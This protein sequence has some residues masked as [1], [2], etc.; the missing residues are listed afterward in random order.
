MNI[1]ELNKCANCGACYNIC[2]QKAI[3]VDSSEF[4]YKP[5]VNKQLCT[6]CGL[7]IDVCPV[8]NDI[9]ANEPI[10]A[11]GGWCKDKNIVLNSSS[12]GVFYGLAKKIIEENGVVYGASY[13]DDN[14]SVVFKSTDET[15]LENLLKSKYVES[16]VGLS[17]NSIKKNL[18]SGRK[19]LFCGTPCQV[20][21]LKS[22]LRKKYDNLI[23]CDFACGGLPSHNIYRNYLTSMEQRYGSSIVKVDFRPKTYGWKRYAVKYDFEND[24][25]INRLGTE[26]KYL[27][28]FLY[29]KYTVRDYCLECK[30]SDCHSSDLT[31]ADFWLHNKISSLQNEN[32]ISLILCN[33]DAGNRIVDSI[34]DEYY[35]NELDLSDAS[36]NN[37]KTNVSEDTK[38]KRSVFLKIYEEQGAEK[39]YN[40]IVSC[41]FMKKVKNH[42]IR[43]LCKNRRNLK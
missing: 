19:V 43:I 6:D 21:G 35:L 9:K 31:I 34:K 18:E 20:T 37:K 36:Y 42:L 23:T 38:E 26:D 39:A 28:C 25:Q 27:K 7:C 32:G 22:F 10:S 4:F 40:S 41:S 1:S 16:M 3:A 33:T 30:F 12:G 24:K 29:G 17:F 11:F 5:T 13:S 8:N 14:K 2:P 15:K